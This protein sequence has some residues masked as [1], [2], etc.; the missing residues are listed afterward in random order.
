MRVFSLDVTQA[1]IQTRKPLSRPVYIKV[2]PEME[3]PEDA[4]LLVV[5][6]LYGIPDRGLHWYITYLEYL[7][8]QL[9][10]FRT[11]MDP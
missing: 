8:R 10:M 4:V 3:F 7:V 1:Y 11:R 2:R 9:G 6:Q 5:K